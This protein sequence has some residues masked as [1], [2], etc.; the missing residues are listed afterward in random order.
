[1][2][3]ILR[4]A[5]LTA[6]VSDLAYGEKHE[7]LPNG[8]RRYYFCYDEIVPESYAEI[9]DYTCIASSSRVAKKKFR[10]WKQSKI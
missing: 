7:S 3:S 8:C 4:I 2:S 6:M 5:L 1:M 9:A 10:K